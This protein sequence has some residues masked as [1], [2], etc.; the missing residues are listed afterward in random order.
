MTPQTRSNHVPGSPRSST[1]PS[2]IAPN[3]TWLWLAAI[4]LALGLQGLA[5]PAV[6]QAPI[7]S[8][9]EL[10][11]ID[12]LV[13]PVL[14]HEALL[15]RDA[16]AAGPGVPVQYAEPIDVALTPQKRGQWTVDADGSNVW[17]LRVH[18]ANAL[19]ISLGFTRYRMPEGGELRIYTPDGKHRI[20]PFTAADNEAHGQLWTPILP[21]DEQIVEVRL[22]AARSQ[23]LELEL[24]RV[25]HGYRP[26]G[27][28]D[29]SG[30][31]NVD[32][33]CP[34][35]DGWRDEI[36]S[37]A[38]IGTGAGTFCTG[39]LVNNTAQ[40]LTPYFMTAFHCG[41]GAGEAPS[42]VVYW[43]YEN[44]TCRPPGSP[45]SGGLGDGTLDQFQTGSVLRSGGAASDFT[46]VELDDD[47]DSAWDVH[48]AGWDRS[49]GDFA[50]AIAIHHPS[51]DEKRISFE[52]D[53]TTTT[54]YLQDVAPGDGSHVRVE[55]WDVG[56]TE[57]GS[58]G[59]PLFSPAGHVIG[60]LHGGFAACGNDLED[61]YG[62]ISVSW[63]GGG[64]AASRLSDWLDPGDTG[65]TT[66]DGR[67]AAPD[68]GITASPNTMA[69]CAG[70]D[71][72]F[73]VDLT[74]TLGF[75]ESV[76]LSASGEPAGSTVGFAANPIV[77][78]GST[79]MTIGNTGGVSAGTYDLTVTGTAL[80][81]THDAEAELF[82]STAVAGAVSLD[83][84]ADA[85]TGQAVDVE[86]SWTALAEA[87][88]YDVEVATDAGF[89]DIVASESGIVGTSWQPGG[90]NGSS[91][92]Y[93]RVRAT[94]GCGD[95]T[96]SATRSFQTE[97]L[98][99]DCPAGSDALTLYV[100]D[101]EDDAADYTTGGTGSTWAISTENVYEG[102]KAFHADNVAEISDQ[103]LITPQILL[104]T[105]QAPLTFQFYN[106]QVLE[107]NGESAC[108]DGGV[109]EISTDG[110]NWT[111]LESELLTD[112]YDGP[113]S[114]GFSNPLADENAW[115][116]DPQEWIN[117]IVDIDAWAGQTVQFRFRLATDT[118]VERPGWDID[119]IRIRGCTGPAI[120]A[121]GFESGDT[122]AWD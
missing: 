21:G 9:S 17:R 80:S 81:A 29:K 86:L 82:V 33:I 25:L 60:Q 61:W 2:R 72:V 28:I 41:I 103:Y 69:I 46:L 13:M 54:S 105:D 122:T 14:D 31:C 35:G 52:N 22:P 89:T 100:E 39:F 20:R 30:S 70:D 92:Y 109:L 56:T 26:F 63:V 34:E 113:I 102:T 119:S 117:S 107:S 77:P 19:T 98:P 27:R 78:P 24:G 111:R 55:D 48:W 88:A 3:R 65:V 79:S 8:K 118:S 16:E 75:S 36:R 96:W 10:A 38:V 43:N 59:S 62:R 85:A 115:C 84:P 121:D 106:R 104:P 57:P 87:A 12:R 116:G 94:N 120:F 64:T 101:M 11:N 93:W 18:S 76:T 108:Y 71:A 90:L 99:G 68:F 23:R 4:L 7:P 51:T 40:D 15:E 49:T 97:T 114:D 44:S 112:P 6:A 74:S 83:Q 67:D 66:L 95:G 32:V 45:A 58:S 53:A 37:V 73:T 50:G 110:S 1:N 5:T 42:L 91:T 47:P